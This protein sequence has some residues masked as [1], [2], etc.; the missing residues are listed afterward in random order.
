MGAFLGNS[1]IPTNPFRDYWE[2]LEF[3]NFN[4]SL[5]DALGER[6]RRILPVTEEEIV[7]LS[8]QGFFTQ[9]C[10]LLREKTSTSNLVGFKD[11]K[12]SLLLPFW[13]KVF[14]ECQIHFSCIIAL[15]DP[16]SV[17]ASNKPHC[18]IEHEELSLWMYLSYLLS[19]LEHSEGHERLLVDYHELLK[20]P[21]QQMRRI[22]TAFE[23]TLRPKALQTYCHDFIDSSLCHFQKEKTCFRTCHFHQ[24]FAIEI[25]KTLLPMAREQTAFHAATIPL[26]QWKQQFSK[27]TSLL[28]LTEKNNFTIQQLEQIMMERRKTMSHLG[29]RTNK[30]SHSIA[31][32]CQTLHQRNLQ[33]AFLER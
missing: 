22:A 7:L 16:S 28:V 15:R 9:A 24:Q 14:Q 20:D 19:C 21:E 8:Q 23:L 31:G 13:K 18:H 25:Y 11:P 10:N 3:R 26:Q 6:L 17:V 30:S 27:A 1:F 2:D 29:K 33:L 32:L 12:C 4:D 5:L